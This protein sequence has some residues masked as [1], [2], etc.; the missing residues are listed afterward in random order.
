[1]GR[2]ELWAHPGSRGDRIEWEPWRRRWT[3]SCRELPTEGRANA[4]ILGLL[5]QRLGVPRA[6]LR[7]VT[8]ERTRA[9]RVEVDGLSG[10]EIDERLRASSD[11]ASR[12]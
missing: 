3:V 4:A 2:I 8:G 1:V 12:S 7:I 10:E 6:S 11:E 5:A 9:K